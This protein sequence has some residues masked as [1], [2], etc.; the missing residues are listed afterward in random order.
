MAKLKKRDNIFWPKVDTLETA[1]HACVRGAWTATALSAVSAIVVVLAASG[2]EILTGLEIGPRV[3]IYSVVLFCAAWGM[4]RCSR[5]AA[6]AALTLYVVER[7]AGLSA[8]GTNTMSGNIM[9]IVIAL[10]LLGAVRGAFAHHRYLKV[11]K[12]DSTGNSR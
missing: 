2:A 10:F 5:V 1:R 7:I 3:I 12:R 8:L 9:S 4:F 11:I 6:A